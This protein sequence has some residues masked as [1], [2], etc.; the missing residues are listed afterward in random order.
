MSARDKYHPQVRRALEK[1]GWIITHDPYRIPVSG[2]RAEIDLAAEM[3]IA[4]EKDNRRIA[5]EIKSFLS[6]SFLTN[7]ERALGQY[8]VYRVLLLAHEPG[9]TLYL[10]LPQ[11]V[12]AELL[13]HAA[14]RNLLRVFETRLIFY[15]SDEEV[16]SEW[17]E[18][19][20]IAP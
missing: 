12:K 10:A 16:L 15:N 19:E 20:N 13:D 11:W 6:E 9:R 7:V 5:I 14:Y 18:T 2:T 4:A 17:I 8:G 3:P 1:D